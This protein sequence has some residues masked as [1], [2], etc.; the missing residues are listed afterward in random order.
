M[1]FNP[2]ESRIQMIITM[3]FLNIVLP[4]LLCGI[5]FFI[6]VTAISII[7]ITYYSS[8][9]LI[10]Y[11][12]YKS[13]YW[14][15]LLYSMRYIFLCSLL[16]LI[17]AKVGIVRN[18]GLY[19]INN[20]IME[21]AICL[22]FLFLLYV[23]FQ[24]IRAHF[25][26]ENEI[27]LLFPLKN[28]H[29]V[30]TDGGNGKISKLLNYHYSFALHSKNNTNQS[31]MYAVDIIKLPKLSRIFNIFSKTNDEY[32]IFG[33]SVYSPCECTVYKVFDGTNDNSPFPKEKPYS[34]GNYIILKKDRYLILLGH[35]KKNS[36]IA[37]GL[38]VKA[39]QL[40]GKIGN[41]GWS[42]R[43]HIHIQA[44]VF[45]EDN[46]WSGQGIPIRFNGRKAIK[47]AKFKMLS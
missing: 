28:G 32:P 9:I 16:I 41:S 40:L 33:E 14:G 17:F 26:K 27:D 29:Y 5:A 10:A 23:S 21:I 25:Y 30:I 39:G 34:L 8:L 24:I 31:M 42:E 43:P 13:L 7:Y 45:N 12:I 22:I 18:I 35:L 3:Y 36:I 19:I 4:I 37:E 38:N 15:E 1:I 46:I 20:V 47:N 2:R 11:I 6:S 44:M